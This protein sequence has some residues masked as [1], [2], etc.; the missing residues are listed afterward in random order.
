MTINAAASANA[1]LSAALNAASAGPGPILLAT[2]LRPASRGGST[3]TTTTSAEAAAQS[4]N[5]GGKN[6]EQQ[7][8]RER[9][10]PQHQHLQHH[11]HQRAA[12]ATAAALAVFNASGL[13]SPLAE[14][15]AGPSGIM[16]PV[17]QVPLVS[18]RPV[19]KLHRAMQKGCFTGLLQVAF[20]CAHTI[21]AAFKLVF[22]TFVHRFPA[23]FLM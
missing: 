8:Q 14:P 16:G 13:S 19:C 20:K 7:Q 11:H 21:F 17:Q 1:N 4:G 23:Q 5:N 15:I 3:T 9:G 22:N 6:G 18:A 12:A 10:S 2:D